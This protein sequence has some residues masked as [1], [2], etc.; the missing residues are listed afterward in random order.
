MSSLNPAGDEDAAT[1]VPL[2]IFFEFQGNGITIF[3]DKISNDDQVAQLVQVLHSNPE[4]RKIR[5]CSREQRPPP[6]VPGHPVDWGPLLREI[7]TRERVDEVELA[8]Y[9]PMP[10]FHQGLFH[11]LQRNANPRM[12]QLA[13]RLDNV[14]ISFLDAATNLKELKLSSIAT[15]SDALGN[16]IAA[17]LQRN[18]DIEILRLEN[19]CDQLV[20]P[21]FQKLASPESTSRLAELTYFPRFGL[22]AASVTE[23]FQH[24]LR[25]PVANIQC[26]VLYNFDASEAGFEGVIDS[27]AANTSVKEV[28]FEEC[29]IDAGDA[30]EEQAQNTTPGALI[31]ANYVRNV[32]HLSTLRVKDCNFFDHPQFVA[33]LVEVFVNPTSPLRSFGLNI[34]DVS[35]DAFQALTTAFVS[36]RTRLE[37]LFIGEIGGDDDRFPL[38]LNIF[39]LIQVKDIT[40]S[41]AWRQ[42]FENDEVDKERILEALKDNYIV[43]GV[44]FKPHHY[45]VDASLSG[46]VQTR[47]NF[48]MERNRKL[49]Q[50]VQNPMTVPRELWQYAMML[51][52]KAGANTLFQSL[53]ALSGKGIGLKQ[54]GRKRKR[55]QH[56]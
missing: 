14:F 40:L 20:R 35:S 7:E 39:P 22:P 32:V 44:Y 56:E 34:V 24:Y 10:I 26:L 5:F 45:N 12:L 49:A 9:D 28:V 51:A 4:K 52:I 53:L 27:L 38:L 50:W 1:A 36:S 29:S 17:A 41:M 25:S 8:N 21:I 13:L 3:M 47:L 33:A 11:A 43:E 19:C 37:R 46:A 18:T 54:R 6:T 16:D 42:W 30:Q 2:P 15:A 23:S 55:L 31:L 48:Y